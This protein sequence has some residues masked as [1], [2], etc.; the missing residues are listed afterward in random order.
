MDEPGPSYLCRILELYERGIFVLL[1]FEADD[2]EAVE[3]R[4]PRLSGTSSYHVTA[5]LEELKIFTTRLVLD[6]F[7]DGSIQPKT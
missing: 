6:R 4:Y 3:E 2:D 5:K 1:H 7:H